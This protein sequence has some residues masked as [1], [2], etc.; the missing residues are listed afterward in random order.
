MGALPTDSPEKTM[1]KKQQEFMHKMFH[2]KSEIQP[3][4]RLSAAA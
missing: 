2:T 4:L 3:A 1:Q